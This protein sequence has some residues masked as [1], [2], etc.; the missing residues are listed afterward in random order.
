MLK[1]AKRLHRLGFAIHWLRSRSKVPLKGGWT[2]GPRFKWSVLEADY[3]PGLNIGVRL[4]E[5]SK[6]A[7]GRYLAVI[8]CDVKSPKHQGEMQKRLV[9]LFGEGLAN[10]PRVATGR[11]NGSAHIYVQTKTPQ[12]SFR[13]GQS[14]HKVKVLMPSVDP[15]PKEQ[16]IMTKQELAQG[17]RLRPAWEIDIMGEGR[18]VVLP[19]SIHPD[20]GKK[21]EWISEVGSV[22]DIPRIKLG[23]KPVQKESRPSETAKDSQFIAQ[24]VDLVGSNLPSVI[25]DR[26]LVGRGCSDRSASLF[27]CSFA[28]IRAGFTDNEILSVLSD[29]SNY[30]GATAYEHAKTSDRFRAVQWLRDYTLRKAK[31]EASAEAAFKDVP[32][33]GGLPLSGSDAIKQEKKTL[34]ETWRDQIERTPPNKDGPGN[35]KTTL[36]N[37]ELILR[38][39]TSD[40]VFKLNEF[41]GTHIYSRNTPWTGKEGAELRDID[42][43]E[44]KHWLSRSWGFEPATA[45]VLEAVQKIA[46]GNRFH[47]VR[48]YL[49]TL[50]WDGVP[51]LDGWLKR[52]LG[53]EGPET[54]LSVVGRKTLVG[55]IKRVME[56]GC[57]FDYVLILEGKQGCGKSTAVRWLSDPWF[58][59]GQVNIMDKDGVLTMRSVWVK[60]L[61]EL[62]GMRKADVDT[63][64][65]FISRQTD[66]IRT[67]YGKL[68]EDF[69]RQCIFIG[70][71]NSDHYLKDPTGNRRFWPVSVTGL[72][73]KAFQR[74]RDQL[75]AEALGAYNLGE[76]VYLETAEEE[77]LATSEQWKRVWEDGW[78]DVIGRYLI[79]NPKL[80]NFTV[81][82]LFGSEG[83]LPEV[84][85]SVHDQMRA[86]ACLKT[87]GFE[88][89]QMRLKGC[90]NVVWN[91]PKIQVGKSTK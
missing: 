8:D 23:S 83:P 39:E 45:L 40:D 34:N 2:T 3:R 44:I 20:T 48:D 65:E 52:Y 56:P 5:A 76:R 75:L 17:M 64:K 81:L 70:T 61:G 18:Q 87:L 37:V 90:R 27:V 62:S 43:I 46:N 6:L 24:T 88:K 84:R 13:V 7:D 68:A 72:R 86:A 89:Q 74:D 71:T 33:E 12:E 11:G 32:V 26:I 47:P 10:G 9:E 58:S 29:R 38:G 85:G 82:S 36:F 50:E 54:Y 63:L 80:K 69:P 78:T 60:E 21:Y 66:R 28:M 15:T 67:P 25:V 35:V 42:L 16:E 91:R 49:A 14:K 59:D 57:K 19:P 53:A 51:R 31:F 79:E 73:R 41:S 77:A 30:L 55:M 1:E 22:T 4:G